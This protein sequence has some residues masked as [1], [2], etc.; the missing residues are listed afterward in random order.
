[1]RSIQEASQS[2]S[3]WLSERILGQVSVCVGERGE[4]CAVGICVCD[5]TLE[6]GLVRGIKT[7]CFSLEDYKI[8]FH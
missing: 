1:M 2:L 7:I 3:D 6:R 4:E 5:C 8:R